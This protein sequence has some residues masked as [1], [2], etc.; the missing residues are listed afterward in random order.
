V[1]N[2][3]T[4]ERVSKLHTVLRPYL[5]RRLKRDVEKELPHKYEH[6]LRVPL[7]K[8]QR[9]LYDEFMSR[10]TTSDDLGSGSYQ[11]IANV[12]MQLRKVCNHPDLFEVRPIVTSFAMPRSAIVD[13]EPTE[14][15]VRRR[16]LVQADEDDLN[17]DVLSLRFINNVN[18]STIIALETRRLDDTEFIPVNHEC[19]E[20]PPPNDTRT[21]AGFRRWREYQTRAQDLARWTHFAYLNRLR[22]SRMPVLGQEAILAASR[23]GSRP[24]LPLDAVDRRFNPLDISHSLHSAIKSYVGRATEQEPIIERFTFATP[25]VVAQDISRFALPGLDTFLTGLSSSSSFAHPLQV[26]ATHKTITFPDVSLL[27]YDCGKLQSLSE[28]LLERKAGGHRVLIFTQ[29][30]R[31]LNILEQWLSWHGWLYLRLDGSTTIED[32]QYITE[33]FNADSRVFC[34]ISSSRSGGVGIK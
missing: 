33:R 15:L 20:Q 30:T 26:A 6:I 8:R 10:R 7:S 27:Q 29:M 24:L 22:C 14:L 31:V 3:E 18:T 5:L 4:Q 28:L 25:A 34:F 12:L 19:L 17:L 32:R 9:L 2:D 1:H 11:R 13:Y 21:L 23:L 16:F